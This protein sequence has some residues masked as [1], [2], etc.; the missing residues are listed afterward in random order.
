MAS[1]QKFSSHVIDYAERLST[2]ADAAEGKKQGSGAARWLVLPATGAALYALAK[3]DTFSK[4]AKGVL[5]SAKSRAADLPEDLVARV[6]E[7]VEGGT[8]QRATGNSSGSSRT[9][10]ARKTK[11]KASTS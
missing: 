7:T 4:Q 3:S 2:M 11:A 8:A 9:T 5:E 10:K 1:V 6:R